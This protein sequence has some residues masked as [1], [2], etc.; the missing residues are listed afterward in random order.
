VCRRTLHNVHDAEDA[1]QASFLVLARRAG[2]IRKRACLASWL[3]SVAYRAASRLRRDLARRHARERPCPDEPPAPVHDVSW[4]D[5]QAVVDAEL[6]RL[7]ERF[8]A[9][10]LLC[11]LEGK[12]RDQ[13]ASELGWSLDTLRGRL[14]RGR[15]LLRARLTRRGLTLS[16]A[17]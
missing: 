4:R 5:V 1:C 17:L 8:R 11:Y 12:T 7:P 13:A 14:E 2:S 3:H 10:L 9:P 16:A 15:N 6:A